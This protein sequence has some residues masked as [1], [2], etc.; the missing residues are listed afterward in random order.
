MFTEATPGA[1][2][3]KPDLESKRLGS[4]WT[5]VWFPYEPIPVSS[6]LKPYIVDVKGGHGETYNFC[7]CGESQTQPWCDNTCSKSKGVWSSTQYMPRRD[8]YKLMCGCKMAINRPKC[9][10]TCAVVY[11][12]H[13]PIMGSAAVFGFGFTL[14]V[15][16]TYVFHP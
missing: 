13:N 10:G 14:S 2:E 12:D 1:T 8:G 6:Q 15:F 9:D 7:P 11:A 3:A 16:V 5:N 4:L